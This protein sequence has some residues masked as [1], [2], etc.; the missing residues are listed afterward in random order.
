LWHFLG[1]P[2]RSLCSL[3]IRSITGC[4]RWVHSTVWNHWT[5]SE[6]HVFPGTWVAGYVHPVKETHTP[7]LAVLVAVIASYLQNVSHDWNSSSRP[8]KTNNFSFLTKDEHKDEHKTL[9]E[10]RTYT[11]LRN[12]LLLLFRSHAQSAFQRKGQY[13]SCLGH[14][15]V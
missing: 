4:K 6:V 9:F 3:P 10:H 8:G 13:E 14:W 1:G 12:Q 15:I 7:Q 11:H 2:E 5:R